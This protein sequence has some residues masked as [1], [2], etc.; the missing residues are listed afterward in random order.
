M[1]R[2]VC[3][4]FG[5]ILVEDFCHQFV[6]VGNHEENLIK[7]WK[8]S[9]KKFQKFCA[10]SPPLPLSA[11]FLLFVFFSV[12]ESSARDFIPDFDEIFLFSVAGNTCWC[13]LRKRKYVIMHSCRKHCSPEQCAILDRSLPPQL[14]LSDDLTMR[15]IARVAMLPTSQ[16]LAALSLA[17]LPLLYQQHYQLL[18]LFRESPYLQQT[19]NLQQAK[20][21]YQ[22]VSTGWF[23]KLDI[24]S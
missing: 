12:R 17:Q 3:E 24:G 2:K 7:F 14:S 15:E 18:Q 13:D 4:N 8:K 11:R 19:V 10:C 9:W 23:T 21:K 16:Q 20:H 6:F 22:N 1:P 5:K